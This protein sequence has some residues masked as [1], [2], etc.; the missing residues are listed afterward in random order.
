[1]SRLRARRIRSYAP[2]GSAVLTLLAPSAANPELSARPGLERSS[3]GVI[4]CS[5]R[6]SRR[7]TLRIWSYPCRALQIRSY[8]PPQAPV[9][10]NL[11]RSP[12]VTPDLQRWV[13]RDA[14]GNSKSA[15]LVSM[16]PYPPRPLSI[17]PFLQRPATRIS[18]PAALGCPSHPAI[19]LPMAVGHVLSCPPHSAV[20]G[21]IGIA[22]GGARASRT[23]APRMRDGSPLVSPTLRGVAVWGNSRCL[24]K[25]VKARGL[26]KVF[27]GE[28]QHGN[29][30]QR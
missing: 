15:A 7:S 28:S 12:F 27:V 6:V 20:W 23:L 17:T 11:Q 22:S 9:T 24:E 4:A 19:P 2:P 14:V 16:A 10:P 29:A 13:R 18:R 30:K 21:K 8:R 1:M 3:F 26:R 5:G 25:P